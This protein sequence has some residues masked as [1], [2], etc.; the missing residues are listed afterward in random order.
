M[1]KVTSE[2]AFEDSIESHLL[3]NSWLK[4]DPS[5]YDR[6]LGLDPAQ[7]V[8]FLKA[9]QPD[10]WEQ[11]TQR[12]GGV[13]SAEERVAKY[14]A[15][16][17]TQRGTIDVLRGV[18][19]MNG[20]SFR[21]AF[22]APANGLTA[23]LWERYRANRLTVVRQLHHSE[24]N[25]ADSV[26]LTLFVNG[27]PTA[28]AEL[29]NP[30]T[31][32]RVGHAIRQY[33]RDRNPSD[34]I[35][36]ARTVVHFAV[37]PNQ[38][39]MTTRLKGEQTRFL[40]FNQGSGGAGQ[41]GGAGNPAN[42]D[43]YDTAYLWEQVWQPDAWLGL[44][45][46]FVHVEDVY[47]A[48][49]GRQ[50]T[51]ETTTLFPRYHQWDAV[52]QLL[53]ATRQAGP[54]T[55]RLVQ[56]SAGSG[57]SNTIAWT[58]HHLSRLHTSSWHGELTDAVRAAG[59]GVDQP[60]FNKVIVITDRVVLD[61]QLQSTVAGFVHTPGTFLKIDEDSAQLRAALAGNTAR[62]IITTLQKFPVVAEQAGSV[63]GSRFAV[64]VD[65]A[66]SSTSGE[67]MKD[68]KRVLGAASTLVAADADP[69][70]VA[71][72]AEAK[73]ESETDDTVDLIASSMTARG[74]QGNL[75]FFAFTATPKP[76][77]LELFG[78]LVTGAD[79]EPVR[80]PFHLYSLRQAIEEGYILDV[81]ANYT[82]YDTYYRLANTE[83]SEDPDVPTSK[84][85]A[86]LA[87]FVSLHPTN[88]AQKAEIIVEHFRQKTA[89]KI[90]GRA[91]AMV[92]TRSRLHA[93]RY[94]QAIDAYIAAKGY[95]RGPG[96]IAALVAFSGTVV[97]PTDPAV[98]YTEPMMNGFGEGK[99]P[100]RF[101]SDEYQV[102][103]VAEKYQTGFDQPLL[104]TMYVDKKLAGVKA[105]QT[106]SRLNR[107]HP[108]KTDTFVLDFANKAEEIQDAF[109]P[110]FEQTSAAP[111]DP[112]LLY[113][114][115]HTIAA[116]HVI[117]PDEQKAAVDALLAGGSVN[118]KIVYANVNPAVGRFVGLDEEAQDVFRDALK[119]FVRT[120]SFLAQ[121]MPWTDRDL[122][123]LYLYGRA[124]LPLLP[125]APGEPLPQ[126]SE[127]VLLTHLR[128]EAQGEEENLS[129]TTGTDEP[130]VA[131]PGGGTGKAYESPME[132]LSQLI[133]HLNQ[134][135]G[136]NLDDAD[137][138]WFEQQKQ[139]I[140]SDEQ[141]RV[142]ALN[143]DRD[144][145]G[146]VLQKKAESMI[147]DRHEA[148]GQLF[149]AFFEKPSFRE[150][151]LKYLAESYDEIRDEDVS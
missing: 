99:L 26:D 94:K 80:V 117:H 16:Q 68:M 14:V 148:N 142:V 33:Q 78:D 48:G 40:P 2:L 28:T 106:L 85:S 20:V 25:P 38:V 60:I 41:K 71:E 73:I 111:T 145:Y 103:V 11:L 39:Y 116:G 7:L 50:K 51:G 46:E 107:T 126:I 34:L 121:V 150:A 119:A 1:A 90:G 118:Q 75:A 128:T 61:R 47:D 27:I 23:S 127:S 66:H 135:Y 62:I 134:R 49:G 6:A 44:L 22:F 76:K 138:V 24:S 37:D 140:K 10:E 115:E 84:A 31:Q 82:T 137:R 58:A 15:D 36:R 8:A 74:A 77:T 122:E 88:L 17:L 110:F 52:Q 130:G 30:L 95:D 86:A 92:V 113:T 120:Y 141:M 83:P 125:T 112:N 89:G 143:N 54:G 29:K 97:D 4:G 151:L 55:N 32:Q 109:E 13:G 132:K 3:A 149:N 129:L 45:G 100:K 131:L 124:L 53:A 56:H 64:I 102:L 136:M 114:L 147:V 69:L 81:L 108:G 19:K 57:K 21:L 67:A 59:L 65:E 93:V 42:A 72:Q 35:F 139:A 101:A 43:G 146:V 70:T 12:L 98:S 18:T 96:R 5:G 63:A 133:E 123:S 105:V 144:Q 91:K 79:G 9:S 104:H 87:R